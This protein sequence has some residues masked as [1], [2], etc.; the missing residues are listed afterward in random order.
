MGDKEAAIISA[1]PSHPRNSGDDNGPRATRNRCSGVRKE[2]ASGVTVAS[3]AL[4][5]VFYFLSV[6]GRLALHWPDQVLGRHAP[7]TF[8]RSPVL[9]SCCR[10]VISRSSKTGSNTRRHMIDKDSIRIHTYR[11]GKRNKDTRKFLAANTPNTNNH[12]Q[13]PLGSCCSSVGTK[14][15]FILSSNLPGLASGLQHTVCGHRW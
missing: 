6:C 2:V 14:N 12:C 8:M 11:R 15:A 10:G 3:K 4:A 13:P 9:F 7:G 5:E 1:I